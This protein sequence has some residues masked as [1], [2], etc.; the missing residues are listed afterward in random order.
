MQANDMRDGVAHTPNYFNVFLALAV[1]TLLE[2]G[3]S[4]LPVPAIRLPLLIALMVAKV[5][6]VAMYY[7]HLKFDS[8][9]YTAIFLFPLPFVLLVIVALVI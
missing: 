6:L 2:V 1:L 5:A 3:A 9:W 4:F 8:R 7:M